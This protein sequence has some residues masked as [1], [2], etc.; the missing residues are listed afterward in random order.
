MSDLLAI[1]MFAG[2]LVSFLLQHRKAM[3]KL[4]ALQLAGCVFFYAITIAL[5]FVVIYFGGRWIAPFFSSDM[6]LMI[7]RILLVV[8]TIWGCRM[9][10]GGIVQ[11]IT[12]P[13]Q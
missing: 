12:S 7:V 2:A 6:L 11:W 13:R 9:L 10:L 3:A 5:A 4:T 8:I 1:M